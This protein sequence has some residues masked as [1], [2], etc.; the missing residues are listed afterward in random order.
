MPQRQLLEQSIREAL[1]TEAH[2]VALS[3][4]LF[5]PNP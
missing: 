3:Q 4:K 2:A 1:T 5:H